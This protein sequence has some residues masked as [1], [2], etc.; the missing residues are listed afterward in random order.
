MISLE[1]NQFTGDMETYI[2]PISVQQVLCWILTHARLYHPLNPQFRF[3]I[4][5]WR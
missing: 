2:R 4:R 1:N 5:C 3:T